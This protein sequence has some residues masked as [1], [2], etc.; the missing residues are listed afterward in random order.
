MDKLE[1]TSKEIK[2]FNY[3]ENLR[4]SG[5]VNMYG[6]RP[7]LERDFRLSENEARNILLKWMENYDILRD[8]L[9]W[10]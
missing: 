6:A 7:Y 1:L 10:T 8:Q 4:K 2:Y 5:V 3:L 9:G